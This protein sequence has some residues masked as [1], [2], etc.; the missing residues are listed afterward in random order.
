[1]QTYRT[2]MLGILMSIIG[3]WSAAALAFGTASL[4]DLILGLG[5]GYPWY[6]APPAFGFGI[7]GVALF[8]FLWI[9]V[10]RKPRGG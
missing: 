7:L 2:I 10:N 4:A 8:R 3:M 5:W 6:V 1:M 9:E